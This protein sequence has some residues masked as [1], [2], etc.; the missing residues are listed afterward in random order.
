MKSKIFYTH[1]K[2][3]KDKKDKKDVDNK[4]YYIMGKNLVF[5]DEHRLVGII[6]LAKSCENNETLGVCS[7]ERFEIQR[8]T[9]ELCLIKIRNHDY[10][11]CGIGSNLLNIA[12]ILLIKRW[13][14]RK[15]FSF[16][17]HKKGI[18]RLPLICILVLVIHHKRVGIYSQSN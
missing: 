7:L 15:C 14:L 18:M 3:K 11:S 16:L 10:D 6:F 5:D 17:H 13:K 8:R 1:Y 9:A 4:P 12:G 2:G